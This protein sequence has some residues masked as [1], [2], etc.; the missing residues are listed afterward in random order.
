[1][2]VAFMCSPY[3]H[4]SMNNAYTQPDGHTL[5][6]ACESVVSP[7]FIE[8]FVRANM[9]VWRTCV[10]SIPTETNFLSNPWDKVGFVGEDN[11]RDGN[12]FPA[13]CPLMRQKALSL[14]Q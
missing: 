5:P 6:A 13:K 8:L 10:V 9:G 4:Y 14:K 12:Y 11:V 1:M 7:S 3:A 2:F